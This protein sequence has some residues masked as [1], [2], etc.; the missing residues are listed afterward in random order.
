MNNSGSGAA[1]GT[2]FDGSVAGTISYNT[3]GAPSTTGTGATGTWSIDITGSA[4]YAAAISGGGTNRIVYQTGSSATSFVTAPVT[5]GTY[6]K[7]N[8]SAFAW[9]APAGSG[10]VSGP[11]SATDSQIAL[12][13]STTGKLIKAAT[14]SGLLKATSGVIAAVS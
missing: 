5:S 13:D 9:D 3:V 14:T 2:T 12:F 10:D 4:G 11:A 8:G 1:S 7:W 6:L